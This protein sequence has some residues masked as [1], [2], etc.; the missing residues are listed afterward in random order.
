MR[1]SNIL[2]ISLAFTT[3]TIAAPVASID[4]NLV[5]RDANPA[6]VWTGLLPWG[7]KQA[8]K[9]FKSKPKLTKEDSFKLPALGTVSDP[10]VKASP[11]IQDSGVPKL[12]PFDN[13]PKRKKPEQTMPTVPET[14]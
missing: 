2:A 1:L 9:L 8:K 12:W 11:K 13:N 14:P 6:G 3:G 10:K 7:F 5:I 4:T